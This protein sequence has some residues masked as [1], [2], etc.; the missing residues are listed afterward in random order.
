MDD[1]IAFLTA[2]LDEDEQAAR[3]VLRYARES[4]DRHAPERWVATRTGPE[5]SILRVRTDRGYHLR[6]YTVV[7]L[8]PFTGKLLADYLCRNDPATVLQDIAAKRRIIAECK[9]SRGVPSLADADALGATVLVF[10]ALRYAY[11]P[12]YQEQWRP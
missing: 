5:K 3:R 12:D 1:L 6:S 4:Y 11:H 2:R 7:D 8:D 10:L 9:P